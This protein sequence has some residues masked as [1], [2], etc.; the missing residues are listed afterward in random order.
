MDAATADFSLAVQGVKGF[1]PA[2][3]R[4]AKEQIARK[5]I[6]VLSCEGPCIRGE[7]ARLA[8][9]LIAQEHPRLARACMQKRSSFRT[10]QWRRGSEAPT[11]A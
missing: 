9:N 3:E 5:T 1:C 11:R 7:I 10:R 6:P 8:A 4:Y 2:G